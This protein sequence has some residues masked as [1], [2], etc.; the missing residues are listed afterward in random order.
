MLVAEIGITEATT[1][2]VARVLNASFTARQTIGAVIE[3]T[4]LGTKK[5]ID[6]AADAEAVIWAASVV[7][8]P[9]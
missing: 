4:R 6:A 3:A 2:E 8:W 5:A 9:S 1:T 7:N